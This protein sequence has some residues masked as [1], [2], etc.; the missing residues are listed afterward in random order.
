MVTLTEVGQYH[1]TALL[2]GRST[3]EP[4]EIPPESFDC[5]HSSTN[6]TIQADGELQI[7]TVST[8]MACDVGGGNET[9][10]Q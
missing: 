1:G 9:D 2:P 10:E 7:W 8:Q 4:F 5:N 3:A 6:V